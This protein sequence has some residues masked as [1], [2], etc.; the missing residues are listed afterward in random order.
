MKT[1]TEAKQSEVKITITGKSKEE[2]AVWQT[3]GDGNEDAVEWVVLCTV[4]NLLDD[5]IKKSPSEIPI[6]Q[7]QSHMNN[8][9]KPQ[10]TT[11][12]RPPIRD[13][14]VQRLHIGNN[15]PQLGP[16]NNGGKISGHLPISRKP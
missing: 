1:T 4:L 12:P 8:M 15:I 14:L 13:P 16:I 7:P 9:V 10:A 11:M 5:Q 3:L 2:K 6:M